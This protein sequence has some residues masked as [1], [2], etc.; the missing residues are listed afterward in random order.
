MKSWHKTPRRLIPGLA[1]ATGPAP[2][3]RL[4]IS[5]LAIALVVTSLGVA[6]G[7]AL[8]VCEAS[9]RMLAQ[10]D[11]IHFTVKGDARLAFDVTDWEL[12]GF[13]PSRALQEAPVSVA[14]AAD[15]DTG[16]AE[17][18]ELWLREGDELTLLRLADRAGRPRFALSL[19]LRQVP[20]AV[21]LSDAAA[22]PLK[23]E[24]DGESL[25]GLADG[26]VRGE[27]GGRNEAA[28]LFS[29]AHLSDETRPRVAVSNLGFGRPLEDGRVYTGLQGGG[30]L[31]LDKPDAEVRLWR[32]TDL[33]LRL[34]DA[35]LAAI[36]LSGSGIEVQVDGLTSDATMHVG[37][38]PQLQRMRRVMP[39]YY[40]RLKGE[41]AIAVLLG[42]FGVLSAAA[43]LVLSAAQ[44]SARV[45]ARVRQLGG[46]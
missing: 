11:F 33:R 18:V 23:V 34:V 29:I 39:T 31:F 1:R 16:V 27:V 13:R 21:Q 36:L 28:L 15:G 35:E 2:T 42:F 30:L 10:T 4:R 20:V 12:R 43:G 3:W 45:A 44:V 25:P 24:R 8:P 40:D 22:E 5:L 17:R 37:S 38:S 6:L 9:F 46:E 14:R 26:A 32:G 41:P 7:F 19:P